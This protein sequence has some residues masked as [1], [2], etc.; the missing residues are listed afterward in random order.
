MERYERRIFRSV[1]NARSA[2][3]KKKK[4]ARKNKKQEIIIR[5][6][7]FVNKSD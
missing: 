2:D 7:G 3:I 1:N 4:H 6:V 5:T